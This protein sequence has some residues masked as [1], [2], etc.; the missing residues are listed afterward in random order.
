MTELQEPLKTLY[1]LTLKKNELE[2]QLNA[3]NTAI[4]S[5][6]I[7]YGITEAYKIESSRTPNATVLVSSNAHTYPIDKGIAPKIVFTVKE[8]GEADVNQIVNY[9]LEKEPLL[10][11]D[12]LHKN[13]TLIAS[14]LKK[15]GVLKIVRKDGLKN[16][17]ALA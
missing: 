12:T 16:I 17:L 10:N 1:N 4:E 9:I 5:I 2:T 15:E 7:A 13:V 6:K 8:L 11:R 3:I 14:N